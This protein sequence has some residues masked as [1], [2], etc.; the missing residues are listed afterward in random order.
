MLANSRDA[1]LVN[2]PYELLDDILDASRR[3]V[4]TFSA[5]TED[6]KAALEALRIDL[7]RLETELTN[8]FAHTVG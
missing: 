2:V 7:S 3:T 6:D 4:D 5:V 8:Y 1:K